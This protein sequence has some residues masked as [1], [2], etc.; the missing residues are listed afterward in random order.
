MPGRFLVGALKAELPVERHIPHDRTGRGDLK[1]V[2][3]LPQLLAEERQILV[4]RAAIIDEQHLLRIEAEGF[5]FHEAHLVRH[6][7]RADDEHDRDAELEDDQACPEAGMPPSP[8]G[9]A[10]QRANG[11]EAR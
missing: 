4:Q 11:L 9:F 2:G 3:M 10:F 6:H 5:V 8:V 1:D 7:Q